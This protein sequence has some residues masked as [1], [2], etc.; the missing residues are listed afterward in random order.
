[1]I[2]A[3]SSEVKS[4]CVTGGV[5]SVAHGGWRN[6]SHTGLAIDRQFEHARVEVGVSGSSGFER[7]IVRSPPVKSNEGTCGRALRAGRKGICKTCFLKG[8]IVRSRFKY[9]RQKRTLLVV[10]SLR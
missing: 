8:D 3:K 4:T 5:E 9:R 1:M 7:R 10:V 2:V 6:L